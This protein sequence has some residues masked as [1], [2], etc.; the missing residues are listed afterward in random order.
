MIAPRGMQS[1]TSMT[2][3]YCKASFLRWVETATFDMSLT[4]HLFSG[5]RPSR[6]VGRA[7]QGKPS[8]IAIGTVATQTTRCNGSY[9][10][11]RRVHQFR[12][13][14]RPGGH[15]HPQ[16]QPALFSG[17]DGTCLR[18]IGSSQTI[19]GL[20]ALRPTYEPACTDL[21]VE[22]RSSTRPARMP[23]C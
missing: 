1:S 14:T 3:V 21:Q 13:A 18:I 10:V 16:L 6:P 2:A 11:E 15:Y 12:G 8:A 7:L 5:N 17:R 22:T 4:R 23:Y 9:G 20:P 19:S